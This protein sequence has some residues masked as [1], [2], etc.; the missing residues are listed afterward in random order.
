MSYIIA[1]V[2]EKGGVAKTT[3]AVSLAGAFVELGMDVLAIDLDVQANLTMALGIEANSLRRSITDVLLNTCSPLRASRET[4][5]PGLDLIPATDEMGMAERFLPIRQNYQWMLK[6]ALHGLNI[7]QFILLDCPP[8]LGAV[9]I[10]ALTAANL[11]IIPTQ[12]EYFSVHA[13]KNTIKSIGQI[14][15][16]TNPNL[17]YR[18]LITMLDIRNRIHTILTEQIQSAFNGQTFNSVIGIDT[19]LRESSVAGLPI[20]YF[21]SKCRSTLQYRSLAEEI[22]Q[23]VFEKTPL[24]D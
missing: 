24:Q 4:S 21:N 14:R 2:N 9:T 11:L 12:A 20:N 3:T 10:N 22:I 6:N 15:Q 7:Y 1:V 23:N 18:I 16:Q 17:S 5:I 8:S 19:K 13:L